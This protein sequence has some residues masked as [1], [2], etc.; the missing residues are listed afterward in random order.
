MRK[1]LPFLF[2]ALCPAALL[3]VQPAAKQAAVNYNSSGVTLTIA[4]NQT[5][6]TQFAFSSGTAGISD[7]KGLTWVLERNDDAGAIRAYHACTGSNS[8]SDTVTW[9]SSGSGASGVVYAWSTSDVPCNAS[10]MDGS[11]FVLPTFTSA[12]SQ[13]ISTCSITT[14]FTNDVYLYLISGPQTNVS[15]TSLNGP[16]VNIDPSANTGTFTQFGSENS[17]WT[18]LIASGAGQT[19]TWQ[20]T[21]SNSSGS[22]GTLGVQ[23]V[24][25]KSPTSPGGHALPMVI[26]EHPLFPSPIQQASLIGV[27][28]FRRKDREIV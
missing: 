15:Y 8:G 12:A 26:Q 28:L 27:A 7:G 5:L 6:W 19:F 25:L 21:L 10:V 17:A 9:L 20:F 3:A 4:A 23:I 2:L 18:A 13:T 16:T 1:L 14:T 22:G 24:A 11:C